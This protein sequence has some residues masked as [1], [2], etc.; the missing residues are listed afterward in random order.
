M[1]IYL[2]FYE[3]NENTI[4]IVSFWDNRQD[5]NKRKIKQ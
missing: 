3:I 5:E 4:E 2:I 1:N